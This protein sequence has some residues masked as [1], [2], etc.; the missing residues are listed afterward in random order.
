MFT[1]PSTYEYFYTNDLRVLVDILIRNLLD[2]PEDAAALR[3]TYLRVLYPLL[4]HTQLRYPPHYK[5]DEIR[6]LLSLLVRG[7]MIDDEGGDHENRMQHFEEVDQTTKRLATRC[8]SVKWLLDEDEQSTASPVEEQKPMSPVEK[9]P[10]PTPRK[11]KK[12]HSSKS[13]TT[14]SNL[15]VPGHLGMELEGAR[16]SSLSVLEVA[17]H[18]EKPGIMTPSRKDIPKAKPEPPKARRSGWMKK[19]S[20]DDTRLHETSGST[21]DVPSNG[22]TQD[23]HQNQESSEST[24]HTTTI[25]ATTSH[26]IHK[27]KPP[28]MPKARRWRGKH[29]T[30]PPPP[31]KVEPP[32][33]QPNEFNDDTQAAQPNNDSSIPTTSIPRPPPVPVPSNLNPDDE[34]PTTKEKSSVSAALSEAQAQAVD[35]VNSSLEKQDLPS[36]VK[37]A[38]SEVVIVPSIVLAPPAPAPPRGVRGPEFRIENDVVDLP[39]I[40]VERVDEYIGRREERSPFEGDDEDED[41]DMPVLNE[42]IEEDEEG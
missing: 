3:H 15:A 19:K 26:P 30:P 39:V 16:E 36:N 38:S 8:S 11:L 7:S 10:P 14:S 32:S 22:T 24:S 6:K 25:T 21:S 20:N 2:L 29:P 41:E 40:E 17:V 27:K 42:V 34:K 37:E 1:T 33:P 9:P 12:R 35:S 13:S 5:R 31:V 4:A 23:T 18:K 28:P